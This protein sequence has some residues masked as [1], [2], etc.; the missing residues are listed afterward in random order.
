MPPFDLRRQFLSP[1]QRTTWP[2]LHGESSALLRTTKRSPPARMRADA[3][4]Y[5]WLTAFRE[6]TAAREKPPIAPGEAR[7]PLPP[8]DPIFPGAFFLRA[9]TRK[10]R[11]SYPWAFSQRI[12]LLSLLPLLHFLLQLLLLLL[13]LGALPFPDPGAL[14]GVVQNIVI[15]VH[16][17]FPILHRVALP[18]TAHNF[19]FQPC[20]RSG[21]VACRLAC[22]P[23]WR[24]RCGGIFT[25]RWTCRPLTAAQHEGAALLQLFDQRQPHHRSQPARKL[26]GGCFI[27]WRL[28]CSSRA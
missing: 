13:F 19:P 18:R 12:N 26:D 6:R 5:L 16:L 22:P 4:K 1:R 7:C 20:S 9:G 2:V 17:V 21:N 15:H 3:S 23:H 27:S 24:T 8:W 28:R 11:D 14:P 25:S 10:P